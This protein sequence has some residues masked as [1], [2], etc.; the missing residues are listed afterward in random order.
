MSS[1]SKGFELIPLTASWLFLLPD[2]K[3]HSP[4]LPVPFSLL[5]KALLFIFYLYFSK[6]NAHKLASTLACKNAHS[7]GQMHFVNKRA[8]AHWIFNLWPIFLPSWF[9][10]MTAVFPTRLGFSQFS[11]M[12]TEIKHKPA[13]RG[14]GS[15]IHHLSTAAFHWQSLVSFLFLPSFSGSILTTTVAVSKPREPQLRK[16]ASHAS[17]VILW[18]GRGKQTLLSQRNTQYIRPERFQSGDKILSSLTGWAASGLAWPVQAG[19]TDTLWGRAAAV[20]RTTAT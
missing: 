2:P 18:G 5:L 6:P 8:H 10:A 16:R 19:W 12:E 11:T 4:S 14:Q 15:L 13:I 3:M 20:T 7:G 1:C 17:T 9:S